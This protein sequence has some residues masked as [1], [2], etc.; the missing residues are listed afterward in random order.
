MRSKILSVLFCL[1]ASSASAATATGNFQVTVT[2]AATCIVD[3]T[4]TLD[5]GSPGVLSGNVDQTTTIGV[6][7]SN[8]TPYNILLDKGANGASVTTRQMKSGTETINYGLYRDSSRTLNWGQTIGTDTAAGTGDGN[9]QN[10]TVFG[11]IPGPQTTP[12]PGTYT[13]TITVTIDY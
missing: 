6:R 13:D 8:T 3:S 12:S 4:S 11:R 9:V 5:F 7:C 10:Y 1:A 2:I